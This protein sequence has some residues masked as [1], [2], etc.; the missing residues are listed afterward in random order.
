MAIYLGVDIGTTSAKCL[1]VDEDG[2]VL[3]QAQQPYPMARPLQGWVEQDPEDYWG[4]LVS[5]VNQCVVQCR[6]QG[7]D[8]S[9][10]ASLAMS[11][12]GDTLIVTDGSGAPLM[13]AISWMDSRGQ[14]EY[15]ELLAQT[16]R[17]FWYKEAATLLDTHSSACSVRW[18]QKHRRE[19][20]A[21]V[22]RVC[23]VADFIAG[24]LSG[25]SASDVPSASWTPL[26]SPRERKWSAQVLELLDVSPES[27]PTTIESEEVIGELLPEIAAELGVGP[28]TRLIAGAFDQTA[29][30]CGV[31]AGPDGRSVL[32]CGTA[33]V[34]YTVSETPP[35]D[36]RE[37]LLICC[38][39]GHSEWGIVLPFSGGS[40]Y[41]WLLKTCGDRSGSSA[42]DSA[43]LIFIPHLYGEI[44]P[45]WHS[46]SRG[47]LLGL[48][49]S[50]TFEDVRLALMRGL[51]CEARRNM[52]AAESAGVEI[53]RVRMVGGAAKSDIWPQIIADV[54]DRPIEVSACAESACYGAAKLAAG[55]L[56]KEWSDSQSVR[57]VNPD[58]AG[59]RY[60]AELFERY[61]Q[62]MDVL[63][64]LYGGK[65][66][67]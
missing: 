38:H 11:T 40:A 39:T 23:Y 19:L 44:C 24:R 6:E 20:W 64:P 41:D 43:P 21:R 27:L 14:I 66:K 67:D 13:P 49:V 54:L 61:V 42:T 58:Y 22:R 52:E 45:G 37:Q 10:I 50:H 34:L 26:Y 31:G 55:A 8:A 5:T 1:A 4:A 17:S 60:Q 57:E 36:M 3:G 30:A 18:L 33:W 15:Q 56:S 28:S 59:A 7:R 62:Y 51:A 25:K 46:E 32:S 29:A 16:G 12:Q 48:S 63:M 53:R 35:M 9:E 47:S 2:T 65:G